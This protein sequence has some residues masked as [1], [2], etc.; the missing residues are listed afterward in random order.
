MKI[1]RASSSLVGGI[2]RDKKKI[3]LGTR[4]RPILG[5]RRRIPN[6]SAVGRRHVGIPG[7]DVFGHETRRGLMGESSRMPELVCK[8]NMLHAR[9]LWMRPSKS[10]PRISYLG[11]VFRAMPISV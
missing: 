1:P 8:H 5:M 7:F 4:K 9:G 2:E 10:D 11:C 3:L 6:H